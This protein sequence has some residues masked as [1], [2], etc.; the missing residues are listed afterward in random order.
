MATH[1]A[2]PGEVVNL[3][4]WAGDLPAEHSKI[5]ART[6]AMELARLVLDTGEVVGKHHIDGPLVVH[7][8]SGIIDILA[9]ERTHTMQS[10]ELLY[11]P[12]GEK[13]TLTARSQALVLITFIFVQQ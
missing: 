3:A 5:I 4:T 10:G 8:L 11:L 13:F 12:P 7:C 6:D 2:A 9:L 1:H